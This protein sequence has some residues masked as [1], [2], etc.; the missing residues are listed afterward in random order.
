ML[1]LDDLRIESF[2]TTDPMVTPDI[3]TSTV[4]SGGGCTDH[5]CINFCP[6]RTDAP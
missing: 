2:D 4:D 5:S 1:R 3:P 6:V